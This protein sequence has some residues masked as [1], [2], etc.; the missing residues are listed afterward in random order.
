MPFIYPAMLV[1]DGRLALVVGGGPVAA[2]KARGLADAGADVLVVAAHAGA[3]VRALAA[4]GRVRMA[5]REWEPADTDAATVVVAATGDAGIDRAVA[6]E[7]R[8]RG[9]LVN[10]ADDPSASTF[11]MPSVLRRGD[12]TIAVSTAGASPAAARRVRIGLEAAFGPAWA[13][14]TAFLRALRATVMAEVR[15]PDRRALLLAAAAE[16]DLLERIEAG[17]RLEAADVLKELTERID[18]G[19]Q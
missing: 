17:A 9:A 19:V 8:S 4:E 12:L 13:E 7:A 3:E 14:Y 10:V 18:G 5:E 6:D 16:G 1:L 11:L 2:R 15:D